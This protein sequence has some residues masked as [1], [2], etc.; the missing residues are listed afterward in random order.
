M[1]LL[2]AMK[3]GCACGN[4]HMREGPHRI[5]IR[6]VSRQSCSGVCTSVWQGWELLDDGFQPLESS[7]QVSDKALQRVAVQAKAV[8]P[9][10]NDDVR[11]TQKRLKKANLR[12]TRECS[13][14]SV[15]TFLQVIGATHCHICQPWPSSAK[16]EGAADGAKWLCE[17]V[18]EVRGGLEISPA[19]PGLATSADDSTAY[20]CAEKE[21]AG[22]HGT[23]EHD[24]GEGLKGACIQI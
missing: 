10:T 18:K 3:Q 19:F 13:L 4:L 12:M 5:I 22:E 14:M 6:H 21:G 15:G 2:V 7:A 17:A 11:L 9:L 24:K 16:A 8:A 1:L 20:R 23:C